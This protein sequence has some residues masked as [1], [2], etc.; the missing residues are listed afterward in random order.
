MSGRTTRARTATRTT[1]TSANTTRT[2]SKKKGRPSRSPSVSSDSSSGAAAPVWCRKCITLEP[3]A[4]VLMVEEVKYMTFHHTCV[5]CGKIAYSTTSEVQRSSS[6]SSARRS[7]AIEP[8]TSPH[9]IQAEPEV[10]TRKRPRSPSPPGV[11]KHQK[12]TDSAV[13]VVTKE[14]K[15]AEDWASMSSPARHLCDPSLPSL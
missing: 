7:L 14:Q 3:R 9:E 15:A 8:T 5:I 2:S 1:G 11:Q 4:S 10:V 13:V 12:V 6:T